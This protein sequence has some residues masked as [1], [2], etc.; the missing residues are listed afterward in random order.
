MGIIA[1]G[2]GILVE[3]PGVTIAVIVIILQVILLRHSSRNTN[4]VP[5]CVTLF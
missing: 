3:T 1:V 5:N 4:A 2:D